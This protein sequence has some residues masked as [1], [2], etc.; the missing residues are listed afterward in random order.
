[1][2][3]RAG[4]PERDTGAVRS[5]YGA[6]VSRRRVGAHCHADQDPTDTR[7]HRAPTLRYCSP[8]PP[9]CSRSPAAV[10]T[11]PTRQGQ[12][13]QRPRRRAS[14]SRRRRR[15]SSSGPLPAITAGTKFGEKP[16]VA[17][18]SGE[19]SQGARG[20]DAHRRAAARRSRKGD[21]VQA[22]YLGQIWNTG[23]V[24]DNTYDRRHAADLPDRHGQGHHGWDAGAWWARRSAAASRWSSRRPGLRQAGQPAGGHQGHRHPG[25]RRRHRGHVQRARAR[26]R[27]SRSRR[28]TP[29]CPRSAPT[30]TARRPPSPSPR[31]DGARRSWSR[32][33]VIEG[34]GD[35]VK[36]DS[37]RPRAVQGR[38]VGRRQGVRLH[39]Q[40]RA[41]R[42][43]SRS[44][45][46]SRAGR[47]A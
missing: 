8:C 33:Y 7:P 5:P 47:R 12:R 43:S 6:R 36:A 27:A 41:A 14:A 20:Q 1:M 13:Q 29:T 40:P 15:R 22:N 10:T 34:D 42:S 18:G 16:T 38:A 3:A 31:A 35:E 4:R 44:S 45:R 2:S 32:E 9:D 46:S 26:P 11:S 17:K 19:P 21:Y 39:L 28:A 30:P 25:L 37:T 23:K 24:F